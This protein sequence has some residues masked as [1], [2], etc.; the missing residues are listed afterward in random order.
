M[1]NHS[2]QVIIGALDLSGTDSIQVVNLFYALG[3][4]FLSPHV[5]HNRTRGAREAGSQSSAWSCSRSYGTALPLEGSGLEL[6][7][8][9][10]WSTMSS[11]LTLVALVSPEFL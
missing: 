2:L 6:K 8:S 5:H 9:R 1:Q 10:F 4:C 11:M 3:D 7:K